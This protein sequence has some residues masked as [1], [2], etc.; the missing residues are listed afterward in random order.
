[1]ATKN[2]SEPT[3]PLQLAMEDEAGNLRATA[4]LSPKSNVTRASLAIPASKIMPVIVVA[5]IMGSNLRANINSSQ[6]PNGELE[7]GRAA[8]HPPNGKIDGL[9]EVKRWHSRSPAVRQRILDGPTLEVDPTGQ[10]ELTAQ[11]VAIDV[12][13]RRG[14]GEIHADSY[15]SLLNNLQIHLNYIFSNVRGKQGISDKWQKVADYDRLNWG[16]MERGVAARLT[17]DELKHAA[18]FYYPVYGFGYNWLETNDIS[19]DKLVERIST[20]IND[21]QSRGRE[22]D[23]VII[24][25]HSM[26]GLVGR[27][28]AKKCPEKILGIVHGVMPALGAPACYRR[29]ACGTEGDSPSNAW[30]ENIASRCFSEITGDN[31]METMPVLST[32]PGPLELLPNHC[33]PKPWLFVSY[34]TPSDGE[35][36]ALEL[37]EG[38]PYELYRDTESWYRPIIAELADPANIYAENVDEKIIIAINKAEKFHKTILGDY[39]HK[40]S[41]AVYVDDE[42][43]LSFG[44][45]SWSAS[46]RQGWNAEIIKKGTLQ[47]ILED[48]S[49][50]VMARD[51]EFRF[52]PSRQDVAGD[53]TV[54]SGSAR[55]AMGKVKQLFRTTGYSHQNCYTKEIVLN[56]SLQL[57]IKIMRGK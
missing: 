6:S 40:N 16:V 42:E 30:Y 4:S 44:S 20:I 18:E 21:W 9:A 23:S 55:G 57:I 47:E 1:M 43:K 38:D 7:R 32:A 35:V 39:Y 24:V 28:C 51:V 46:I 10:I 12:A 25:T 11:S 27:A 37:P 36:R 5:G 3:R 53:G 54:P 26:G 48:G 22:C 15:G 52:V 13:R 2:T 56:L 34:K 49:R 33:Y 17:Q 31:P 50:R 19:S 41:Y 14:W 45:F 8:W 29:I